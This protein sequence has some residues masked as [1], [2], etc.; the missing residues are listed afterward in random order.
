LD[1]LESEYKKAKEKWGVIYGLYKEAVDECNA[2][3]EKMQAVYEETDR[4]RAILNEEFIK[5]QQAIES[6]DR[7]WNEYRK[8]RDSHVDKINELNAEL[9]NLDQEIRK[10]CHMA[11]ACYVSSDKNMAH[12]WSNKKDE[13]V[14]RRNELNRELNQYVN[15]IKE[16]KQAAET[17]APRVDASDYKKAKENFARVKPKFDSAKNAFEEKRAERNRLANE[18]EQARRELDEAKASYYKQFEHKYEG[19]LDTAEI[20]TSERK[21]TIVVKKSNKNIHLYYGGVGKSDGYGH[22][23]VVL[24]NNEKVY[25]RKPFEHHGSQNFV[26][27]NC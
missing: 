10:C 21:R 1:D 7:I 19:F 11:R 23:H 6:H 22:A 14:K 3:H 5:L 15:D 2:A 13:H 26:D 27:N 17:S 16:K 12:E 4:P 9:D 8:F 25:A 20:P 18:R 24:D